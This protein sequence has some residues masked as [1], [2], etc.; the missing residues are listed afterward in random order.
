MKEQIYMLVS[1]NGENVLPRFSVIE[2]FK[3]FEEAKDK[4][5]MLNQEAKENGWTR[6]YILTKSL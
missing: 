6:N 1:F 4:L 3:T 2:T 5:N